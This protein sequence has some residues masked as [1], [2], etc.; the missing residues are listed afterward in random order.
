MTPMLTEY[1]EEVA[2][3][4]APIPTTLFPTIGSVSPLSGIADIIHYKVRHK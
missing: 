2:I 1:C 3:Y 4:C